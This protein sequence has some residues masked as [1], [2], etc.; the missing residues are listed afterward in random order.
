[1]SILEDIRKGEGKTIEFKEI[2]P[3]ADKLAK[4]VIAFANMAGGKIIIGVSDRGEIKGIED[5]DIT[6]FYKTYRET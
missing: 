4:T 1:M 2:M 3:S 5:L 6:Q